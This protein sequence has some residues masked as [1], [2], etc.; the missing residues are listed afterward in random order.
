MPAFRDA[1]RSRIC[2]GAAAL[3]TNTGRSAPPARRVPPRR[4]LERTAWRGRRD[5]LARAADADPLRRPR[6]SPR[7]RRARLFDAGPSPSDR[8]ARPR[9]DNGREVPRRRGRHRL[10]PT[11]LRHGSRWRTAPQPHQHLEDGGDLGRRG[12]PLPR[13]RR[14]ARIAGGGGNRRSSSPAARDR[15]HSGASRWPARRHRPLWPVPSGHIAGRTFDTQRRR[16]GRSP[17]EIYA[18]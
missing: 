1:G 9:R 8:V 4:L 12:L 14:T 2:G 7:S 16:G 3:P 6:S 11:R 10:R 13:T 5:R 15:L 17:G 18:A